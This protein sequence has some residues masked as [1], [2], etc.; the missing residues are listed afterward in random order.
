MIHIDVS[1][2]IIYS[3]GNGLVRLGG[4]VGLEMLGEGGLDVDTGTVNLVLASDADDGSSLLD[5]EAHVLHGVVD[6]A[7]VSHE[8]LV[9][10]EDLQRRGRVAGLRRPGGGA[11]RCVFVCVCVVA[12]RRNKAATVRAGAAQSTLAFHPADDHR[13][14]HKQTVRS[15]Q[16][17]AS[18]T[19]PTRSRA[20]KRRRRDSHEH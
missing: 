15:R 17:V 11:E 9:E 6:R 5:A 14:V 3:V 2:I 12:W 18:T 16:T 20:P 13:G 7:V 8:L 10:V 1:I 4:G 19:R